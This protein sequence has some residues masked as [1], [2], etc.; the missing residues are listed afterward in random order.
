MTNLIAI[1]IIMLVLWLLQSRAEL[2][3]ERKNADTWRESAI[4]LN[5]ELLHQKGSE[6]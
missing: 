1:L 4:M 2:T 6:L 5:R 3:R